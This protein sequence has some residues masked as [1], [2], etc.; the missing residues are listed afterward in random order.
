MNTRLK[1]NLSAIW[2]MAATLSLILPVFVPSVNDPYLL[3]TI[4]MA[5]ATMF[6]LSLPASLFTVAFLY[7]ESDVPQSVAIF[8]GWHITMVRYRAETAQTRR[9]YTNTRITAKRKR[10]S[11][12][13]SCSRSADWISRSRIPNATRTHYSG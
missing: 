6:V 13:R 4:G 3:N 9:Q 5:A 12:L 2:L 7:L 1:I 10:N 8:R 11:A